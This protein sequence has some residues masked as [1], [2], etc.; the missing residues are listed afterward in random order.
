MLL[1]HAAVLGDKS[2]RNNAAPLPSCKAPRCNTNVGKLEDLLRQTLHNV[3]NI[4]A[5]AQ[6]CGR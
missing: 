2:E 3:G 5:T 6:L 1:L 4:Q